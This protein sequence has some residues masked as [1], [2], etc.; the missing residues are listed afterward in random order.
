VSRLATPS[1]TEADPSLVTERRL[2]EYSGHEPGPTVLVVA[3][4]HG[5]EPAGVRAARRVITRLHRERP[6]FAGDLVAV[7]GNVAALRRGVRQ[8]DHD[9]N[10]V[11]SASRLRAVRSRREPRRLD[12]EDRQQL[13][14]LAAID[15]VT[16]RA[17]G[18]V[19]V[20]DLHTCSSPSAPFAIVSDHRA[21]HA[22]AE[23]LP[24]PTVGGFDRHLDLVL[25]GYLARR[26]VAAIA[27]E[28]G[29]HLDPC[30]ADLLTTALWLSL[31]GVGCLD[32]QHAGELTDNAHDLAD[33][34]VGLPRHL[35]VFH[36]HRIGPRDGF[37]MLPGYQ[38]FSPVVAGQVLAADRHGDITAP[39]TGWMLLPLYQ[40]TGDDGFFLAH[41]SVHPV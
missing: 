18:P 13:E 32:G 20:L 30:S 36:R 5:N 8:V 16:R 7:T 29:Q 25:T 19:H 9:L 28:A 15:A 39:D 1:R 14:L 27:L 23:H 2:G 21:S 6:R 26:G 35:R 17:R 33:R 38:S 37:H 24:I 41:E 31:A 11:W 40:P 10:R 22:L 4:L 34:C 3:G 12:T